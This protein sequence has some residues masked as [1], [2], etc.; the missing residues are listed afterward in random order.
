MSEST[1]TLRVD[2]S[3]KEAFT[4]IAKMQDRTC[5]QLIREFMRNVVAKA[6]HQEAYNT[7][8][9]RKVADGKADIALGKLISNDDIV[10]EAEARKVRLLTMQDKP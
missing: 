2:T 10:A 7:W 9:D 5:A 3:L 4:A 8:F 1:F 6:T